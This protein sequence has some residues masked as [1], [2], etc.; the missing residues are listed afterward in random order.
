MLYV[1]RVSDAVASKSNNI[2]L[3][4]IINKWV[5]DLSIPHTTAG[6]GGPESQITVKTRRLVI[7]T[8][9]ILLRTIQ[10]SNYW[11]AKGDELNPICA[12]NNEGPHRQL[13]HLRSEELQILRGLFP[14][15]LPRRRTRATGA[16]VPAY[17]YSECSTARR[18]GRVAGYSD[19]GKRAPFSCGIESHRYVDRIWNLRNK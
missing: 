15:T 10:R 7:P 17:F 6:P 1:E 18:L 4:S 16:R 3:L 2:L 8:N 13:R 14:A 19:G 12:R 5:W 9:K 11:T